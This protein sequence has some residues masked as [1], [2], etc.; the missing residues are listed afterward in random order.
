MGRRGR[1][2]MLSGHPRA[3]ASACAALPLAL[4]PG[5]APARADTGS[6]EEIIVLAQKRPEEI[7]RV[8]MALS[9]LTASDLEAQ[10]I[11]SIADL[12]IRS[13]MLDLEESV[14]AA[15]TT[16]SGSPT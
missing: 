1:R 2:A 4:G 13:P 3:F 12:A 8:P 11:R 6:L 10:G 9:L 5:L 14:T 7:G 15:T 16:A